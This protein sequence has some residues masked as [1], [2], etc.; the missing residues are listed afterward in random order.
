[1]RLISRH[2]ILR[3][4]LLST[5]F[6]CRDRGGAETS[7]SEPCSLVGATI[8]TA[9]SAI[10]VDWAALVDTEPPQYQTQLTV[11]ETTLMS[12]VVEERACADTLRAEDL[13]P[14]TRVSVDPPATSTTVSVTGSDTTIVVQVEITEMNLFAIVLASR[15]EQGASATILV[16][17]EALVDSH[18]V[19]LQ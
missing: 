8:P 19:P 6:A 3:V 1:M 16:T 15:G 9:V 4:A 5:L 18:H 2:S 14:P 10:T 13:E 12:S 11:A 7:D 17:D